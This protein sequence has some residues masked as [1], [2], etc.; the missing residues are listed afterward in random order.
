MTTEF[1]EEQLVALSKHLESRIFAAASAS[2]AVESTMTATLPRP[3]PTA[4]VPEAQAAR[5]L[6]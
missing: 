4:G 6:A 1:S 5:T 2:A 3:T